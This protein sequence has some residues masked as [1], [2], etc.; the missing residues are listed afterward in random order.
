MVES[1]PNTEALIK[2]AARRVFITKGLAATRTEDI[3]LEAGV[4]KALVNYYY[5]SKDK[6]FE[7]V[8]YEEMIELTENMRAVL[9]NQELT[10]FEKIRQL[11]EG[12]FDVLMKNPGLPLFILNEVA[13]NPCLMDPEGI[14]AEHSKIMFQE[15]SRLIESE[16][17]KGTIRK[18]DPKMLW[19]NLF[20]LV[21]MPFVAKSWISHLFLLEEKEFLELMRHRRSHVADFII[22]NIRLTYP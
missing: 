19:M 1:S 9:F 7:A 2:E 11:V 12:D 21:M 22:D 13:R 6:L 15:F 8:F 20:S 10:V 4:N 14:K 5:R 3:A 17:E 18:I 16:I